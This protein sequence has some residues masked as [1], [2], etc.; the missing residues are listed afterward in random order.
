MKDTS[1]QDSGVA[2]GQADATKV[3]GRRSTCDATPETPARAGRPPSSELK[4]H[5]DAGE[6]DVAHIPKLG[7]A[8]GRTR[9]TGLRCLGS[10]LEVGC[11][12]QDP[13]GFITKSMWDDCVPPEGH[14]PIKR[15]HNQK[16]GTSDVSFSPSG[17]GAICQLNL[18]ERENDE[19]HSFRSCPHGRSHTAQ[20]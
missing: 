1:H 9:F 5:A 10:G 12:V 6:L 11:P 13:V 2:R 8:S 16:P 3:W 20:A 14:P 18:K 15:A 7:S 17:D 4:P 19:S